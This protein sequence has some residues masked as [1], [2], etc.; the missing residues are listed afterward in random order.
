MKKAKT[1]GPDVLPE[2]DFSVGTRGKYAR[3]FAEGSNVMV[4]D[5]D[6]ARR[7]GDSEGVNEALRG[8]V[9]LADRKVKS[10]VHAPRARRS[11]ATR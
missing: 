7:F 5:P 11:G 9:E 4:I 2:Y 3:Q 1:K 10:S 6:L 8:L